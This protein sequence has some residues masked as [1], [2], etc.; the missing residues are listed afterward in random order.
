MTSSETNELE[1]LLKES[2][3]CSDSN[4]WACLSAMLMDGLNRF[5]EQGDEEQAN[6]LWFLHEVS[7]AR[8]TMVDAFQLMK[9][10]KY[11]DAWLS[12][13]HVEL[14]IHWLKKNPFR[15][16]PEF[17]CD[18]LEEQVRQWQQVFPYKV[19]GSPEFKIKRE[20]CSICGKSHNPWSGCTHEIGKVYGGRF[21]CRV[22][23]DM[24]FISI[25]LVLEPVQKYSVIVPTGE[26]GEDLSDYS[27]V[28]SIVDRVNGPFSR[29]RAEWSS[30]R[31]PHELFQDRPKDGECP[32]GSGRTYAACCHSE[33][34][35][36]RP[37]LQIYFDEPVPPDLLDVTYLGYG[38][39]TVTT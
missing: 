27:L 22:I 19:F 5:A 29:W 38:E 31:H 28:K 18:E 33:E 2:L 6:V 25:A 35:V 34:G 1:N 23:K 11:K 9:D 20:E 16:L 26:N 36:L 21:C 14:N 7:S 24:E 8:G 37:H 32:C 17:L 30:L 12:L 3:L 13:E 15:P 4:F 39:R 10:G